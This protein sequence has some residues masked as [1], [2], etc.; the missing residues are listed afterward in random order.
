MEERAGERGHNH[1]K[2]RKTAKGCK[3][4]NRSQD[5]EKTVGGRRFLLR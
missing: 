5:V 4:R 3:K 2:R 1:A